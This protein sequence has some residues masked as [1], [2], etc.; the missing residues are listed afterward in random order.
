MK[1]RAAPQGRSHPQLLLV[2]WLLVC[3]IGALRFIHL[4]ADFP[5]DSPW[6]IDQAKF[7]DEGWWTSAAVAH[8]ITGH[9]YVPGDYNPAVVLPIWPLLV[10]ALFHF[11]GLSLIAARALS[12]SLSLATLSLVY[13]LVRR[14]AR[15]GAVLPACAAIL[16]LALSAFAFVFSRLAILDT[17]VAFEFCLSLLVA[18]FATP[19]RIWPL[20]TLAALTSVMLLTKTTA[21]VLI[22]SIC[23]IAFAAAG[24]KMSSF[25]RVAVAVV[26][27]PVGT[28][29]GYATLVAALGYG[30]DYKSFFETNS[31]ANYVWSQSFTT[32]G[33][34]LRN[35]F[36]IDYVLY[37]L[38][39]VILMITVFWKRKLWSNP[40]FTASWLALAGAVLYVF[41]RQ[42]DYA[43]RYF[44]DML[45][46][47]I[48]IVV[49]ALD[50]L[51]AQAA[52][53]LSSPR[54]HWNR[55]ALATALLILAI[56]ASGIAN[57]ILLAQFLARPEYQFVNAANSIRDLIRCHPEQKPLILG[58]SGPQISLITGIP[59]INDGYG[60]EDMSEKIARYQPG[61]YLAWAGIFSDDASLLAP[62]QLEQ[63]ASYPVFDDDERT[64]L[65]LYKM[66]PRSR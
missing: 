54:R 13:L 14:Y 32:L 15:S 3:A 33:E 9:W 28:L 40:L 63:V 66:T 26:V 20:A 8:A 45:V 12:V 41:R 50:E 44:L 55:R 19:R 17:L 31:M 23:W 47:V 46:P 29:K 65:I 36:W 18:S 27:I 5:N 16:L 49:L 64:P 59:A 10:A 7:T 22:P 53:T 25:L 51:L 56:T 39:L 30:A 52:T 43:P 60:T 37:P 57:G 1:D 34:L 11:A 61:W 2:F 4:A 58:V 38:A 62:Y 21:A 35:G 6:M 24:R 42:E 48:L